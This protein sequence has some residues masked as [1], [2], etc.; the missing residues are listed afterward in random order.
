MTTLDVFAAIVV[1][2]FVV[3]IISIVLSY[4]TFTGTSILIQ[5]NGNLNSSG[6]HQLPAINT[7]L[8]NSNQFSLTFPTI[9]F[10]MV[11][12]LVIES[13]LLSFF[14]KSHPLAAVLAIVLLFVYA[15]ISMFV[16][17][18]AIS[19]VRILSNTSSPY[20]SFST[21][22]NSAGPLVFLWVNMPYILVF[23]GILDIA[24]AL[25]SANKI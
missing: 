25:I 11:L 24:V 18:A 20:V 16:S 6:I 21:I 10:I 9:A 15:G 12:I 8:Q 14:I 13:L 5:L 22:I 1:I 19:F 23:V 7:L 2:S 17:N 4:V 3:G